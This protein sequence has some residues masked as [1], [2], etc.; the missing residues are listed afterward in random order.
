MGALQRSKSD[1]SPRDLV[2]LYLVDHRAGAEGGL[3]LVR[4]CRRSNEG[5]PLAAVLADVEREIDEDR[6]VLDRILAAHGA[7]PSPVKQALAK[8]AV[9]LGN[10][11]RNGTFVRY[12]PLSRVVELEALAGGIVVKRA[13]WASLRAIADEDSALDPSELDGLISR[14]DRQY[15][16]VSEQH[17]LAAVAAFATSSS[18]QV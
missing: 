2:R 16:V 10:V 12:S 13:L 17:R 18:A 14:A 1:P 5:T 3:A 6:A 8:A 7:S 9:A 11:K 15:E 4:R